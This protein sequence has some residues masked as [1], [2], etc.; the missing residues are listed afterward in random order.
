MS[1]PVLRNMHNP[2]HP[3]EVLKEYLGD[4]TLTDAAARLLIGR[5]TLHRIVTG[6]A[7]IS[8]DMACRLGIAFGTSPELWVGMQLQ[9]DLYQVGK[10]RSE[11]RI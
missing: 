8:P 11:D 3:G 1:E 5:S 4:L 9:Y 2:P 7:K 6:A 10:I